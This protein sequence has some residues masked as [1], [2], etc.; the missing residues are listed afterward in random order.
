MANQLTLL[1]L[2]EELITHFLMFADLTDISRFSRCGKAANRYCIDNTF[3]R[4][5]ISIDFGPSMPIPE[6][7]V[8]NCKNFYKWLIQ[9]QVWRSRETNP[10]FN[11]TYENLFNTYNNT[12]ETTFIKECCRHRL[13]D[14]LTKKELL[15][16]VSITYIQMSK[17]TEVLKSLTDFER[18]LI[19]TFCQIAEKEP[20]KAIDCII[21][22]FAE[23]TY[24]ELND[25]CFDH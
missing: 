24:T 25:I 14:R 3:W 5:K 19:Q 21:L 17:N 11:L 6:Q 9:N 15:L 23:L 2:P 16:V 1:E 12:T 18:P 7:F 10:R 8:Q 13:T 22:G 4:L 20:E